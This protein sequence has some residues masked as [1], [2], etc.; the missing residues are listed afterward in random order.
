MRIQTDPAT[1]TGPTHFQTLHQ[2][3]ITQICMLKCLQLFLVN[4][5]I[6]KNVTSS[7]VSTGGA[8]EAVVVDNDDETCF[9]TTVELQPYAVIDLERAINVTHVEIFT[10]GSGCN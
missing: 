5:A 3:K 1:T 10:S 4:W 8:S 6:N 7:S 2:D 9:A